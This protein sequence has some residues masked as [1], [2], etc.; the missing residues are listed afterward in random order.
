MFKDFSM[1]EKKENV[2][3][4]IPTNPPKKLKQQKD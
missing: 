1:L 3:Q 4:I 2:P